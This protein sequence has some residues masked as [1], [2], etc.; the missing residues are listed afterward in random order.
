VTF[1]EEYL[2]LDLRDERESLLS[3][4]EYVDRYTSG[5][6]PETPAAL[7]DILEEGVVYAFNEADLA[8]PFLVGAQDSRVSVVG[9]G[10]VRRGTELSVMVVGGEQP[11]WPPDGDVLGDKSGWTPFPGR[12]SVRPDPTLGIR[13]RYLPELSS[14]ARVILLSRIDL[15]RAVHDVRYVNIDI[16]TS[17]LVLCD[18]P[19]ALG[20]SPG[21]ATIEDFSMRLGRYDELFSFALAAIYVP[22]FL[23][24]NSRRVAEREFATPFHTRGLAPEVQRARQL[25]GHAECP[26]YRTVRCLPATTSPGA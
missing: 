14:H 22:V 19:V 3:M 2:S 18:D 7:C 24:D 11:A 20:P 16:G 26:H 10:Y 17:Y 23:L 5:A 15:V 21:G 4:N 1:R 8:R 9:V 6:F 13:D 12:E 25:L